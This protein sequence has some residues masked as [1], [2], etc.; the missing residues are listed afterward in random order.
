MFQSKLQKSMV[1]V[2]WIICSILPHLQS[3]VR[4]ST[5]TINLLSSSCA[6]P[7]VVWNDVCCNGEFTGQSGGGVDGEIADEGLTFSGL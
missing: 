1:G 3:V 7:V 6:S 2:W 4:L 5:G